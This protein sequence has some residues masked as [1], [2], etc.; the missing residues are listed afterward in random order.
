MTSRKESGKNPPMPHLPA[1]ALGDISG[2]IQGLILLLWVTVPFAIALSAPKDDTNDYFMATIAVLGLV[3][4]GLYAI[5]FDLTEALLVGLIFITNSAFVDHAYL[6]RVPLLGGNLYLSDYYTVLAASCVLMVGKRHEGRL[7]GSYQAYFLVFSCAMAFSVLLGLL[8]G[9]EPHYV[10]RELHPLI[11]YPLAF[12]IA[13]RAFEQPGAL[14]RI[15]V[16]SVGIV[17]VSCAATFWQLFLSPQFQFMTFATPVYG[18]AQGEVLDAQLIRPPSDWLFL[19]FF[20]IA[21]ATYTQ[22]KKHRFLMVAIVG[23]DALC[24]LL[25]YSRTM[26]A[27]VVGGLVFL[28]LIRKRRI[29]P[30]LWSLAK[31]SLVMA[32]LLIVIYST[33]KAV[34]P[35]YSEAF[36]RRILGS[37]ETSVVDSDEPFVLGSRVY[38]TEMAIDQIG[39]H[40]IL[41]LGAGAAYREILPFEFSQAEVAENPEDGRHFMHDV[42]L[43]VWMKYG[44]WGALAAG[45]IGWHFVREA[46]M[47]ARRPGPQSLLPQGIL[48]AFVGF[49]I[50][51]VAAP[52][53]VALPAVPVLVG[54]MAAVIE[55]RSSRSRVSPVCT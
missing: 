53:F 33:V 37:F 43:F 44:L 55:V 46:W 48:I 8:K 13:M 54:I 11:Y 40:P 18:L 15:A 27:A 17:F 45:W 34:A 22:W 10:L 14:S 28:G 16:A 41:G 51:N 7:F 21:V 12:F 3:S 35:G 2:I 52:G 4:F 47:Q 50:A 30:F 42:Y 39:Q 24:I 25:G 38:E 5:S 36:Q 26:F 29:L 49:A 19:G 1:T 23:V 20:L 32:A 9:A 31:T 6:P